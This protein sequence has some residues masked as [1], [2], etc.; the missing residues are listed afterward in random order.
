MYHLWLLY[1]QLDISGKNTLVFSCIKPLAAPVCHGIDRLL[2]L[3]PWETT[4]ARYSIGVVT[5]AGTDFTAA[6]KVTFIE[7]GGSPFHVEGKDKRWF[8]FL[9]HFT[10]NINAELVKMKHWWQIKNRFVLFKKKKKKKNAGLS[11]R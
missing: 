7:L 8:C 3:L 10:V 4:R 2:A 11:S 6:F 1:V 9:I 5:S